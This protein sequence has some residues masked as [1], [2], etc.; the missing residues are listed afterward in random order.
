MYTNYIIENNK[1][2]YNKRIAD[3][4]AEFNTN[5]IY[6]LFTNDNHYSLLIPSKH[7]IFNQKYR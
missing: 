1:N 3:I 4:G 7:N 6:V 5:K 2:Y